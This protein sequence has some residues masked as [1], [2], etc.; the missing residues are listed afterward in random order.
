MPASLLDGK[1]LA[2]TM[3]R[4]L[5]TAA[6]AFFHKHGKRPGLAA[7]LVGDNQASRIYVRNKRRACEQAGFASWL[8]E[9]PANASQDDLLRLIAAL[10]ADPAVHG[11]LVQL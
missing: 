11:I 6:E 5:A 3:Q 2:E 8:H 4:E 1:R 9:L 7:V 10:N